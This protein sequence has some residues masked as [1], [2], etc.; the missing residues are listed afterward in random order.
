M[1]GFQVSGSDNSAPG[2][3]GGG[4]GQFA[5]CDYSTCIIRVLLN[6]RGESVIYDEKKMVYCSRI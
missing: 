6:I 5:S 2:K 1:N 3:T 4:S